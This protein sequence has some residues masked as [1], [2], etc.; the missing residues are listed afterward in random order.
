MQTAVNYL[1]QVKSMMMG[2]SSPPCHVHSCWHNEE[3]PPFPSFLFLMN[4]DF[5]TLR[6][7]HHYPGAWTQEGG[8]AHLPVTVPPLRRSN[9]RR[10]C[11]YATTHLNLTSIWA[12]TTVTFF[13]CRQAPWYQSYCDIE[14]DSRLRLDMT[15]HVHSFCKLSTILRGDYHQKCV[16][17]WS[18]THT[19]HATSLE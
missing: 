5:H 15:Y 14:L 6:V 2:R 4:R 12:V 13:G 18:V 17:I 1:S 3:E 16:L 8:G 7:D 10:R 19:T 9:M 11:F